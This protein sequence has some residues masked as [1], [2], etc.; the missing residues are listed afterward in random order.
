MGM[1]Q[2]RQELLHEIKTKAYR[3]GQFRLASGQMSDYYIDCRKV[4]LS[5]AGWLI[6]KIILDMVKDTRIDA[7]GGLTLG[8]DPIIGA[9]TALSYETP[10]PID[11]FIVRKQAKDHG[12]GSLIEGPLQKGAQ[13]L[14]V[15]DVLTK[16]GSVLSAIETVEDAGCTVAKVIVIVNRRQGG[17]ELLLENGYNFTPIFQIE[18]IRG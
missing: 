2:W 10:H 9:V 11:G 12:T 16:G 17:D 7:V 5:P 18:E 8:A 4:T 3:E 14:I 1:E 13:V 6:G 15:D